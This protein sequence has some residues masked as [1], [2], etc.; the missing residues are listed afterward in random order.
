MSTPNDAG[1]RLLSRA[2]TK[3]IK[4]P[5]HDENEKH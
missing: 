4:Q 2:K 5:D 1:N 3:A